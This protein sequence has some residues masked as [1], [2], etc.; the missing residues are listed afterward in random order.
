MF[1]SSIRNGCIV[2]SADP[3]I[4]QRTAFR[5]DRWRGRDDQLSRRS[6]PDEARHVEQAMS[7]QEGSQA[8][9]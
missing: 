6:L 2:L 1:V 3:D 7:C 4:A 5:P 9:S 8:V